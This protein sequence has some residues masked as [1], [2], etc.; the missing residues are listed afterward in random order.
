MSIPIIGRRD[1]SGPAEFGIKYEVVVAEKQK[2]QVPGGKREKVIVFSRVPQARLEED[3]TGKTLRAAKRA[4]S[5]LRER[6][7]KSGLGKTQ[8]ENVMQ[9]MYAVDQQAI[10]R[11]E[12]KSLPTAL[13]AKALDVLLEKRAM[14]SGKVRF[15]EE[16]TA[17][18]NSTHSPAAQTVPAS[19]SPTPAASSL[20]DLPSLPD[21]PP[22]PDLPLR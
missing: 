3:G 19:P 16:T 6:L 14:K 20:N 2:L 12:M 8:V 11:G 15:S 22:L 21:L 1:L 7:Q 5:L 17:L 18:P 9:N 13:D 4:V 10:K